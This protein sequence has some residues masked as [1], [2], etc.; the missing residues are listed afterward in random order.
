M[1]IPSLFI[2][3]AL[4]AVSAS[5]GPQPPGYD[6]LGGVMVPPGISIPVSEQR[7]PRTD[8]IERYIRALNFLPDPSPWIQSNRRYGTSL[9]GSTH[10][11]LLV[12]PCQVQGYGFDE[13]QRMG[14]TI[15]LAMAIEKRTGKMVAP[16]L[17]V[18][19]SLG[20]GKRTFELSDVRDLAR[21]LAVREIVWC[22]AGHE[23]EKRMLVSIAVTDSKEDPRTSEQSKSNTEFPFSD[24]KL[25][26]EM[27]VSK[28]PAM[29]S[30][31]HLAIK[32]R[33]TAGQTTGKQTF[34]IPQSLGAL[35]H[36]ATELE[37]VSRAYDLLLL[38]AFHPLTEAGTDTRTPLKAIAAVA[39]L[40][41]HDPAKKLIR[42]RAFFR[43]GWRPA[44]LDSLGDLGTPEAVALRYALNGHLPNLTKAVQSVS[45]P[46]PRLL[47]LLDLAAL[48]AAYRGGRAPVTDA[49]RKAVAQVLGDA[50]DF[51]YLADL[52]LDQYDDWRVPSNIGLKKI[53][54]DIAPIPGYTADSIAA[55]SELLPQRGA[56]DADVE[57]S[58]LRHRNMLREMPGVFS[59]WEFRTD[60]VDVP[61]I[62]DMLVARSEVNLLARL[63]FFN[64]VQASP[65]KAEQIALAYEEGLAGH[66]FF[67]IARARIGLNLLPTL[68]D[69]RKRHQLSRHARARVNALYHAQHLMQNQLL[70]KGVH[71][72]HQLLPRSSK[73]APQDEWTTLELAE[74]AM[75]GVFRM[76]Y[77]P[78]PYFW[79]SRSFMD[80]GVRA[81]LQKSAVDYTTA[82]FSLLRQLLDEERDEAR[83]EQLYR[84]N[85]HRF[86]GSSTRAE[87]DARRSVRSDLNPRLAALQEQLKKDPKRWEIRW[88]YG[89]ALIYE[90]QIAEA[91]AMFQAYPPFTS[92]KQGDPLVEVSNQAYAAGSLFYW[93]GEL[94]AA[95][96]L[97][98]ISA[99]LDTGSEGSITSAARLQILDGNYHAATQLAL[100]RGRRYQSVYALRDYLSFLHVLG[101]GSE[102]WSGF[103]ALKSQF[104]N[105][106]LWAS[107]LVGHQRDGTTLDEIGKWLRQP[108]IRS[109]VRGSVNFAANHA[110]LA[111]VVDRQPH[112]GMVDLV[113]E[114]D[115]LPR[116]FAHTYQRGLT[117]LIVFADAYRK[118]RAKDH[119]GAFALLKREYRYFSGSGESF[120]LPYY[121][122]A[123]AKIG[124]SD[125]LGLEK[126]ERSFYE[127]FDVSLAKAFVHG[128]AGNHSA[129][130]GFLASAFRSRPHTD[131]RPIFTEYQYAQACQWLFE[132]TGHEEYRRLALD[133]AHKHQRIQPQIAWA[134]A[135]EANLTTDRQQRIRALGI[136]R[137]LDRY[138]ESIARFANTPEAAE[139]DAWF[140]R[141]NPF[142]ERQEKAA[143]GGKV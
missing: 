59:T 52:L 142:R 2:G 114:I 48:E 141:D 57:L 14:M 60:G 128:L 88:R 36:R 73:T 129:A 103:N 55:K 67:E 134:Y 44:A 62:L 51:K 101:Y 126:I 72:L 23:L 127:M 85:H 83:R 27:F 45:E 16:P 58:V 86:V 12:V 1:R 42:A 17:I 102:A 143:A 91:S 22:Y 40:P 135:M 74:R 138:S 13:N 8:N 35:A 28:L 93:L 96:R 31:L 39:A 139:A 79:Q 94:E 61:D 11:D 54:D 113:K 112:P 89:L 130:V 100:V 32:A 4:L 97:Y 95:R 107:V 6:P 34:A 105:P 90:G 78:R 84:E 24:T 50:R 3:C 7:F 117:P 140:G 69:E 118:I 115:R 15:A 123:A 98:E 47:A 66:P 26:A 104:E 43:L 81:Q 80:I 70:A 56:G 92:H 110:I 125:A 46:I 75:I 116:A 18:E 5:A 82:D 77:P 19:K 29:L 87:Y 63:Y 20:Q 64:V 121:A 119:E 30:D 9:F 53:L 136:A 120:I 132:D 109:I 25:P 111:N 10:Y 133:W 122:Y 33:P 37:S 49:T 76:D 106:Q 71:D 137:Y 131:E 108:H 21:Q 124:Q 99:Q 65:A 38:G 41:D 68:P